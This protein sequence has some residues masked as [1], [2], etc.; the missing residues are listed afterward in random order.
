[1]FAA[2]DDPHPPLADNLDKAVGTDH[3]AW[4]GAFERWG[5][6]HDR[7]DEPRAVTRAEEVIRGLL[8]AAARTSAHPPI[9]SD[10]RVHSSKLSH[11][12][13]EPSRGPSYLSFQCRRRTSPD[14]IFTRLV[15]VTPRF[16]DENASQ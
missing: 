15:R 3:L 14:V 9:I 8:R 6:A 10:D 2:I 4:R 1:M 13:T 16:S 7:V 11:F 12:E 5:R